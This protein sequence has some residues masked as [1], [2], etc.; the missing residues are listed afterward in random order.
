M[1]S[2]ILKVVLQLAGMPAQTIADINRVSPAA[3]RLLENVKILQPTIEELIPLGKKAK[4]LIDRA[5]PTIENMLPD[6]KELIPVI[7]E[8]MAFMKSGEDKD[9]EELRQT[10]LRALQKHDH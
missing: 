3:G 9:E 1:I 10:V 7:Q 8:V 4:P 2:G 5:T 6:I